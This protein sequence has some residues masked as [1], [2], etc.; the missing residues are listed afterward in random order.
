MG[1][2][3]GWALVNATRDQARLQ[4]AGFSQKDF[5]DRLLSAG[6]IALPLVIR[7]VFG[8]SMWTAVKGM[9]FSA[10]VGEPA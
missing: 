8:D 3:T 5:H 2:A 6:S 9:I 7:H 4:N 10:R 1:Y